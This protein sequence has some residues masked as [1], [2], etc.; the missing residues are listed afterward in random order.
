MINPK[1]FPLSWYQGLLLVVIYLSSS[2]SSFAQQAP[3]NIG[4]IE[5]GQST[6]RWYWD[7][8]ANVR[9]YEVTVDGLFADFTRDPQ[10]F[11]RNLWAGD[12]SMTVVAIM[13]DGRRSNRSATAK[14]VV[15]SNY[16][17]SSPAIAFLA[18]GGAPAQPP[19]DPIIL[20]DDPQGGGGGGS[21]VLTPQ[22]PRGT[23]VGQGT[24]RWEWD[25]T[26]GASNY[27]VTVDGVVVG[28]TSST[29]IFS[30]NLWAG[31]HSLRLRAVSSNGQYS[32]NSATAKIVVS[33]SYNPGNPAQ[34]FVVGGSE[35]PPGNDNPQTNPQPAP[36]QPSPAP[37]DPV[38]DN[39]L[40]DVVSW[41]I[42]EAHSKPGY[43]LV[44]SDEFNSSSLNPVRWN[45]QLR[46]DGE[47]NGERYE[48]RVINNEDQFY[49]NIL[50]EDQE[51]RN[52][53]APHYNP[54]EFN[55]SRMAI[56]A[57]RNPLQLW[58]GDADFGPLY[59]MVSQQTFMS[60]AIST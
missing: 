46:W 10:F 25:W 36:P 17:P 54:F 5:T 1:S 26:P 30:E 13:N 28:N 31:D 9:H 11:S 34:S 12:H 16:N 48:Y 23:E 20:D 55:G 45:S 22:N 19:A 37:Q 49:V 44:F 21:S 47:F 53:V 41:S 6:V 60:G 43:E 38:N 40:V 57:I 3:S 52:T 56:R 14:I 8:I 50:S 7:P 32:G 15:S 51:H 27:E 58:E 39:G 24:V 35:P 4:G 29:N 33:G 59:N 42:P 2:A 18:G